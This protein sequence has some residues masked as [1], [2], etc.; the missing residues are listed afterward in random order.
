MRQPMWAAFAGKCMHTVLVA[1]ACFHR[2]YVC[3][4][5][6]RATPA[7]CLMGGGGIAAA[8]ARPTL[9]RGQ[10]WNGSSSTCRSASAQQRRFSHILQPLLAAAG[11]GPGEQAASMDAA[12]ELPL[13]R[14]LRQQGFSADG[15]NRMQAA[16]FTRGGRRYSIVTAA[17]ISEDKLQ[18]DLAPTIAALRAEGLDTATIEQ[19]F[20]QYPNLLTTSQETFNGSL[21]ALRRLADLLPDDPRAVQAPPG[22]TPLGAVLW[23]YP[24]AAAHLL[25]R[26]NLASMIGGNLRLRRQLGI[27]DADTAA[28]LFRQKATLVSN[29]ER[30][31]AMVAHLQRLQASGELSAK[32]GEVGRHCHLPCV[33]WELRA[34][35]M[36]A[37]SHKHGS[38]AFGACI[39]LLPAQPHC[40]LSQSPVLPQ[41]L[42]WR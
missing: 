19:L 26:V 36:R 12:G 6:C 33:Y 23:L 41:W 2:T 1:A 22:A 38:F 31:E 37:G 5:L 13:W 39:V 15:I 25:A 8:A 10:L 30:A 42:R 24:T 17:R 14:F 18:R 27:S 4:C 40:P 34:G 16:S 29:F 32:Q 7:A 28:A 35:W 21:A 9:L 3:G 20:G 11:V